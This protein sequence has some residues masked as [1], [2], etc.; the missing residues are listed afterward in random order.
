MQLA[1]DL[2][3]R[4]CQVQLVTAFAPLR[5]L[6]TMRYLHAVMQSFESGPYNATDGMHERST[7]TQP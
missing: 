4:H 7:A 2:L 3:G 1:Q 6:M 5:C